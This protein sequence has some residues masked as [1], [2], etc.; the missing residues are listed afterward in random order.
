MHR[1]RWHVALG[2]ATLVVVP[3]GAWAQPRPFGPREPHLGYVY[4]AGGRQADDFE[5]TVGG[6]FLGRDLTYKDIEVVDL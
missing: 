6:Q 4:P 5:V 1:L 3:P 2:L